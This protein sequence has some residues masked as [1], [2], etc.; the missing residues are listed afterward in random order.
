M[1]PLLLVTGLAVV[2]ARRYEQDDLYSGW[3]RRRGIVLKR[4]SERQVL[5]KL[6]VRDACDMAPLV[7]R[8]YERVD[9]VLPR[10]AFSGQPMFPVTDARG[11]LAG[12]LPVGALA[13]ASRERDALPTLLVA[14]LAEAIPAVT[15]DTP[16]DDVL[17]RMGA[18]DLAALPVV[19]GPSGRLM[20]LITRA[21]LTRV[22][23]RAVLLDRPVTTAEHPVP[24]PHEAPLELPSGIGPAVAPTGRIRPLDDPKDPT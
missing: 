19:E 6:T 8:E 9:A 18:R 5:A 4:D 24:A 7:V 20:G 11:V 21:H 16:L 1:P 22:V 13:R 14:D 23:E 3:L 15:L 12:I 10:V 2:I 17:R